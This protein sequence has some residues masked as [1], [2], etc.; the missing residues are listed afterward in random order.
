MLN[1]SE[2][3][4]EEIARRQRMRI[5]KRITSREQQDFEAM[6]YWRSTTSAERMR[7]VF[8]IT[9]DCCTSRGHHAANLGRSARSITRVAREQ[10]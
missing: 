9:R 5:V 4:P 6:L 2:L 10:R 8:E 3:P 7:A 1:D